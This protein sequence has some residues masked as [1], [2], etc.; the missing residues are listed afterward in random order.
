MSIQ[1]TETLSRKV[2]ELV[3][4]HMDIPEEQILLDCRFV[5]DLGFDSLDVAEF[6]MLVEE[7]FDILLPGE[8]GDTISTVRDAVETIQKLIA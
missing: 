6:I 8:D 2:I 1:T 3:S 7:E 4:S 5:A